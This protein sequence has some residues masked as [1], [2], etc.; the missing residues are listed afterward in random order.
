M[1]KFYFIDSE[2]VGDHWISLLDHATDDDEIL[3]FYT[4]NSPHM[5]YKNLV[6]LKQSPKE[7][8]FVECSS[9]NNALDFQLSTSLGY[10]VHAFEGCEFIIVSNDTGYDAVVKFW[11][12]RKIRV[13]R[14][15]GAN[16]ATK[17]ASANTPAS[18]NKESAP[19]AAEKPPVQAA[20]QT[21]APLPGGIDKRALEILYIVG[22]SNLQDL[23][24][25]LQLF[26]PKKGT[27]YYT[28]FKTDAAYNQFIAAHSPM[29]KEEKCKYYCSLVFDLHGSNMT[30]PEDFPQFALKTWKQKMNLNSFRA[31]LQGKYGKELSD[32]YYSLFKTQI[33][34]IGNIG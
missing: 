7:I 21:P 34:I 27:T 12:Q 18:S 22:K 1:K 32:K 29:T 9:G 33:K 19:A 10:H 17:L 3:V 23:H 16:C 4:E 28:A 30:M 8:T 25:A 13:R 24:T 20:S 31:S 2:N 15:K 14:I 5:N 26:G 6:I 11:N